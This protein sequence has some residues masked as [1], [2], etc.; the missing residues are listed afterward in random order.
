MQSPWFAPVQR[1]L[2][3]Q[4]STETFTTSE[5]TTVKKSEQEG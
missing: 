4:F 2:S 5:G 1:V 3:C